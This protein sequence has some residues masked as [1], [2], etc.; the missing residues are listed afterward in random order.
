MKSKEVINVHLEMVL[1]QGEGDGGLL[2][3]HAENILLH[4]DMGIQLKNL[5][6]CSFVLCLLFSRWFI[7]HNKVKKTY[8]AQDNLL[9]NF[10]NLTINDYF[11]TQLN[12]LL[13]MNFKKRAAIF[14]GLLYVYKHS[15]LDI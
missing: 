3:S 7:F 12:K 13:R 9:L 14:C 2:N 4:G 5:L 8:N 1:L 6:N 10:F 11:P 15:I